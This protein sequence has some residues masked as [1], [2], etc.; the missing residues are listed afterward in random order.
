[1]PFISACA[2][3]NVTPG[4]SRPKTVK[5]VKFRGGAWP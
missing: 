2:C 3:A 5:K 4:L 1:M